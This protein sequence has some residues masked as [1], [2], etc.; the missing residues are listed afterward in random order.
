[1]NTVYT[2]LPQPDALMVVRTDGACSVVQSIWREYG[3]GR[4]VYAIFVKL[5]HSIFSYKGLRVKLV[6]LNAS[7]K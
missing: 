2:C 5:T 6:M 4:L 1:M 3:W 7:L